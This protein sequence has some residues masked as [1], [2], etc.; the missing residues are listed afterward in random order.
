MRPVLPNEE[1]WRNETWQFSIMVAD[2]G[3]SDAGS[4]CL[5]EVASKW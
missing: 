2:N 4:L 1:A 5:V 3:Q